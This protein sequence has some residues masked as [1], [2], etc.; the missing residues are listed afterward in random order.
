MRAL[1][2]GASSTARRKRLPPLELAACDFPLDSLRHTPRGAR[3]HSGAP[4]EAE[5]R[6]GTS[7][8]PGA[9]R[10]ADGSPQRISRLLDGADREPGDEPIDEE[11]VED[12]DGHAGDEAAGHDRA[13]EVD[14]SVH[15]AG[16]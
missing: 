12:G 3:R 14:G 11:V 8:T 15:E 13:P 16:W 4:S 9:R 2:A 5:A 6:V 10:P 1:C 7:P